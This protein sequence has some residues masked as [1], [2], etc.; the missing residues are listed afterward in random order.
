MSWFIAICLASTPDAGTPEKMLGA[1][2]IEYAKG[3]GWEHDPQRKEPPPDT[4]IDASSPDLTVR[5]A[6]PVEKVRQAAVR[7]NPELSRC[8]NKTARRFTLD[9]DVDL[10][11]LVRKAK[12]A[13]TPADPAFEKCVEASAGQWLFERP[14]DQKPVHVHFPLTLTP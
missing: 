7:R 14:A 12:A 10:M 4:T 3:A 8:A 9:F 11:G 6:L 13:A 5:G 1:G 2:F